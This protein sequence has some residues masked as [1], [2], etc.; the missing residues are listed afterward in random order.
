MAGAAADEEL[1]ICAG[2]S[3]NTFLATRRQTEIEKNKVNRF[4]G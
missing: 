2:R 3:P 4:F 1:A